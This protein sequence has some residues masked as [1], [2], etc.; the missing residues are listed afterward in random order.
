M[1]IEI[2]NFVIAA[3]SMG[4]TGTAVW[5]VG[6][7]GAIANAG[8]YVLTLD[9]ISAVSANECA[10]FV[11]PRTTAATQQYVTHTNATSKIVTSV[12]NANAN[13]NSAF[14]W[15]IVAAPSI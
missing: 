12:D 11:T 7:T 6:A 8:N 15:M 10:V 13:I 3:G 2:P 9:A 1:A 5:E 14:D 4:A